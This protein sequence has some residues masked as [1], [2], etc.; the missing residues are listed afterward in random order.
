MFTSLP[1]LPF[2]LT[3]PSFFVHITPL[4]YL[5]SDTFSTAHSTGRQKHKG[6]STREDMYNFMGILFTQWDHSQKTNINNQLRQSLSTLTKILQQQRET[7]AQKLPYMRRSVQLQGQKT[8]VPVLQTPRGKLDKTQEDNNV[9]FS[10]APSS[11]NKT[12][13]E[14]RKW[15]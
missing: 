13:Q 8:S 5:C 4:T 3:F 6:P 15:D 1:L 2:F 9:I 11:H 14:I 7:N 10:S 12:K